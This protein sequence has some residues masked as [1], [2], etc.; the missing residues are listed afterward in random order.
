MSVTIE[1]ISNHL[2]LSVSTVSKALNGYKDVAPKT[3]ERVTLAAR[4]LGYH[5][6]TAAR[7]LR[8]GRTDKIGLL[9]NNSIQFVSEYL[10]EV[11][12]GLALTAEEQGSNILLYTAVDEREK[13]SRIC[14]NREVD[15]L[16]VVWSDV[17]DGTIDLI[18]DE[19]IPFVVYGR[20]V[21]SEDISYVAPDNYKGAL[22]LTR[23]LIAQGHERI[24]FTARPELGTTNE[25]RFTGYKDALA[26]AGLPL[27]DEY[28]I[29]TRIEPNSGYKAMT[30]ILA[31]PVLPTALFAIYDL[32]AVDAM[33]CAQDHGLKIPSDMAIAGFDGLLPSVMTQP[34]I[35]TVRQP[36]REM[37]QQ[38]MDMLLT[39]ISSSSQEAA[40]ITYPIELMVRESTEQK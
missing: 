31:L 16:I 12:S 15:G 28:I 32:V 14:R 5:P 26:E 3:R 17:T 20:R 25:D 11:I 22:D 13:I 37:A 35:T 36:L 2:N 8:R 23:H 24:A 1:D 19:G 34:N 6:N 39:Q 21:A 33:R 4:D 38:A 10:G 29:Q 30:E 9:L 40:H 27:R 18:H 7:N